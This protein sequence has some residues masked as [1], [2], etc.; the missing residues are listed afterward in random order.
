MMKAN[1]QTVQLVKILSSK[2]L[3]EKNEFIHTAPGVLYSS[4]FFWIYANKALFFY[5]KYCY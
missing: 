1:L 2:F 5:R 4:F 3:H